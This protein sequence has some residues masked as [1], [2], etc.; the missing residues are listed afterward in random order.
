MEYETAIKRVTAKKVFKNSKIQVKI[1]TITEKG[2]GYDVIDVDNP[3]YVISDIENVIAPEIVGYPAYDQ[4]FIDAIICDTNVDNPMI[5]MS[6]SVSVA[7][8]ASNS[9]NI[10]MFKHIGGILSSDLP[11]VSCPILSDK[12]GNQLIVFPMAESIGE[13][14]HIYEFIIGNIYPKYQSRNMDGEFVCKSIFDNIDD[15]SEIISNIAEEEDL[16][17]LMGAKITNYD[18]RIEGL[19]Y[20]EA[21]EIVDF[22]GLLCTEGMDEEADISKINPYTTGSLTEMKYL[23][24]YMTNAGIT[25]MIDSENT[26]FAHLAIGFKVPIIKTCLTSKILNELWNVERVLKNPNVTRF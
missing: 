20:L 1:S 22:D 14:I 5:T 10:P 9:I 4:D 18:Q 8:A 23:I 24:S 11:V 15:F 13:M 16:D 26:S 12:K 7:R 21:N 19:D 25:P 6:A 3:E 2:I 17:I